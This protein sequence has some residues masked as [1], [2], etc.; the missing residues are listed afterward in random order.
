MNILCFH[1]PADAPD[2]ARRYWRMY[3]LMAASLLKV[4]PKARFIL[5]THEEA[6]VPRD[7]TI[8][9]VIRIGGHIGPW[10]HFHLLRTYGWLAYVRSP[11]FDDDTI[12]VDT[13]IL[14]QQDPSPAFDGSFDIGLT[15]ECIQKTYWAGQG[16]INSGVMFLRPER[17]G[18]VKRFFTEFYE[19][20][21]RMKDEP[22]T[23][24]V[25]DGQHPT[26]K[27]WGGDEI[28]LMALFEEGALASPEQESKQLL[29]DGLRIKTFPS[30]PWNCQICEETS[31]RLAMP[32][33][34]DA[35]ARHFNGARKRLIEDYAKEHL[36][37][38]FEDDPTLPLG[39]RLIQ[40][41]T[42]P[43][44]SHGQGGLAEA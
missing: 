24:F 26:L 1:V 32:F 36:G 28:A 14:F 13:D 22:D 20:L 17:P 34:E 4:Q 21:L 30:H 43:T 7:L 8:D 38:Y 11:L 35:V 42:A 39:G 5:I 40:E 6:V 3:Q 23:R 9:R 29:R 19:T 2:K 25:I 33:L 41:E 12:S 10:Y 31:G 37:L 27:E 18:R 15:Y 44:Q 16:K